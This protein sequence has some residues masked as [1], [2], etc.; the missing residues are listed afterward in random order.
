M[1]KQFSKVLMVA[2]ILGIIV[3]VGYADI[4]KQ[5]VYKKLISVNEDITQAT[6]TYEYCNPLNQ[7]LN[8]G[9][10]LTSEYMNISRIVTTTSEFETTFQ[11]N[12][13]EAYLQNIY[14]YNI[15]QNNK[16]EM[17]N[18][19]GKP[20]TVYWNT[21]IRKLKEQRLE[22]RESYKPVTNVMLP[23]YTCVK[24]IQTETG[25]PRYYS[26]PIDIRPSTNYAKA[27]LSPTEASKLTNTKIT[28]DAWVWI[29][30]SWGYRKSANLTYTGSNE[31][32]N[33]QVL[34]IIN[35]STEFGAGKIQRTCEDVRF[36]QEDKGVEIALEQT[37]IYCN[38]TTQDEFQIWVK[39]ENETI[40]ETPVWFYYGNETPV[41]N[42]SNPNNT[43]MFFQGFE[44]SLNWTYFGV[45]VASPES[46][47]ARVRTE[48]NS[49][50]QTGW[51]AG[52][53][54]Q[55]DFGKDYAFDASYAVSWEIMT[56]VQNII[57]L[58]ATNITQGEISLV[59]GFE[60]IKFGTA[61]VG[62]WQ[63]SNTGYS[64]NKWYRCEVVPFFNSYNVTIY[65]SDN[66]TIMVNNTVG[67]YWRKPKSIR[68][69]SIHRNDGTVWIDNVFIRNYTTDAN[70][71][72]YTVGAEES[73]PPPVINSVL[74]PLNPIN[75]SLQYD[76]TVTTGFNFTTD[77]TR[78]T[79]CTYDF[80]ITIITY[81]NS[82]Q[83]VNK[84]IYYKNFTF[85]SSYNNQSIEMNITCYAYTNTTSNITVF[86]FSVV[87]PPVI[88]GITVAYEI[89]SEFGEQPSY[90]YCRNS[91]HL[92]AVWDVYLNNSHF[93]KTKLIQCQYGCD[94]P[95]DNC[96]GS[97][98]IWDYVFI[99][100]TILG[101]IIVYY[102]F[103]GRT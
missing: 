35:M 26:E 8:L 30:A 17:D 6:L 4:T 33:Y 11:V 34:Y 62:G 5:D 29:N 69:L 10:I 68:T 32:Q 81:A 85:N 13:S 94:E 16:T 96:K 56:D 95:N 27:S 57:R 38:F 72:N 9:K 44:E 79:N 63:T 14:D 80:N 90:Y 31:L 23:A 19:T 60:G 41:L 102:L 49:T 43:F 83:V 59:C 86:N 73:R 37:I 74:I 47:P 87:I 84:T 53:N 98:K 75:N 3:T 7:S 101:V 76:F 50:K 89:A 71:N 54:V 1:N 99:I 55:L 25:T 18:K 52:D 77:E 15:V 40:G 70:P 65:D 46:T 22:Y 93:I 48:S 51:S 36:T 39:L 78:I 100:L 42:K 82:S 66:K 24:I 28:Q 12:Y 103:F 2:L 45:D 88:A 91:S 61:N 64:V 67:N 58:E 97:T 20:F 21:T 92:Q